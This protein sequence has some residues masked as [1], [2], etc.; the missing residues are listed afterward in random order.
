LNRPTSTFLPLNASLPARPDGHRRGHSA[1]VARGQPV[2]RR[3]GEIE[4]PAPDDFGHFLEEEGH[5]QGGDMRAVDVGVGHDDDPVI[6]QV[7]GLQSLRMPQPSAHEVG[8]FW[9]APILS[10]VAWRR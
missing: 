3:L 10:A 9:L 7:V 5:Q 2:E 1:E 4:V 8:D 6:A